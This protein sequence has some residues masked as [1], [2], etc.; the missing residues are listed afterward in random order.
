MILHGRCWTNYNQRSL[1]VAHALGAM[2]LADLVTI[3]RNNKVKKMKKKKDAEL[4]KGLQYQ[5]DPSL[6]RRNQKGAERHRRQLSG[7]RALSSIE[8]AVI[9]Q[10]SPICTQVSPDMDMM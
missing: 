5:A 1:L 3:Y 4:I 6:V 9:P 2:V 8:D 10:T 7:Q